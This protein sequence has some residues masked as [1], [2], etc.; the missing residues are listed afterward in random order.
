MCL[1]VS[2]SSRSNFL[3]ICDSNCLNYWKKTPYLLIVRQKTSFLKIIFCF[4][5]GFSWRFLKRRINFCVSCLRYILLDGF[6]YLSKCDPNPFDT[7]ILHLLIIWQLIFLFVI[8]YYVIYS[9]STNRILLF[10]LC[11]SIKCYSSPNLG[12]K[13][14]I[15]WNGFWIAY[16]SFVEAILKFSNLKW[17][18]ELLFILAFVP[19]PL[20]K[21]KYNKNL[22]KCFYLCESSLNIL[23]W[24]LYKR[25]SWIFLSN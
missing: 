3:S 19:L 22:K 5:Y 7:F 4:Y 1:Y 24:L 12:K 15:W 16:L 18:Q 25:A 13:S 2:V 20:S 10:L 9:L 23:R 8:W 21:R 6:M 11:K 17:N 14:Y